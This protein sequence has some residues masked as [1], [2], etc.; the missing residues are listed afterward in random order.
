MRAAFAVSIKN[1]CFESVDGTLKQQVSRQTLGYVDHIHYGS[2]EAVPNYESTST[3]DD[4]TGPDQY[5]ASALQG[6]RKPYNS[7]QNCICPA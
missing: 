5:P 7:R 1:H 6:E 2:S 3:D 4:P